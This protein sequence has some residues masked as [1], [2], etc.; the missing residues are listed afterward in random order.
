MTTTIDNLKKEHL[1]K[2]EISIENLYHFRCSV[3]ELWWSVGDWKPVEI[4]Y[5][6]HCSE[7]LRA[8]ESYCMALSKA[9]DDE[10]E[11]F[12]DVDLKGWLEKNT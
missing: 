12:K 1:G 3:C 10:K 7:P 5:C 11:I 6:P 9:V 8:W 2:A 4:I